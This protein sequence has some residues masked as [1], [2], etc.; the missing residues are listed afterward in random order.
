[1]EN[2]INDI[3]SEYIHWKD[4]DSLIARIKIFNKKKL[5]NII[6]SKKIGTIN[7]IIIEQLKIFEGI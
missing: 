5:I 2:E 4:D 1:M 6:D 3:V 7:N